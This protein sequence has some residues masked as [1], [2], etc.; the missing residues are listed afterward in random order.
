MRFSLLTLL[1]LVTLLAACFAM[2]MAHGWFGIVLLLPHLAIIASVVLLVHNRRWTIAATCP[3]AYLGLWVLTALAGVQAVSD[4]VRS[5]LTGMRNIHPVDHGPLKPLTYDPM[6][7][8]RVSDVRPPWH[9]VGNEAVPCPFIVTVDYGWM[10]APTSGSGGKAYC[11]WF[12]GYKLW[13]K[14]R[15]LWLS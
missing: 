6:L 2:F 8:D 10:S 14:D 7:D 15:S 3:L 1:T 9:F 13:I 12:F 11:L 5:R 4:D